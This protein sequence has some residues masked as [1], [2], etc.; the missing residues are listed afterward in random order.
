M[1]I[2]L[3]LQIIYIHNQ[4]ETSTIKLAN[5]IH[6]N[7]MAAKS[8]FDD[9][10]ISCIKSVSTIPSLLRFSDG[11]V[12]RTILFFAITHMLQGNAIWHANT[13]NPVILCRMNILEEGHLKLTSVSIQ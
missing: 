2:Q 7:I 10:L 12:E 13:G 9:S 8:N 6:G 11:Y 3:F 4:V 1:L 5:N